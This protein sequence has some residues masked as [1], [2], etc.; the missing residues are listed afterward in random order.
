MSGLAGVTAGLL[1]ERS[2]TLLAANTEGSLQLPLDRTGR[3]TAIYFSETG[4]NLTDSFLDHWLQYG[5]S[6]TFGLPISE[7]ITQNGVQKQYFQNAVL[8]A[9]STS[10]EPTGVVTEDVGVQ[11]FRTYGIRSLYGVFVPNEADWYP[12]SIEGVHPLL[13]DYYRDSGSIAK[14]GLPIS[15]P[16]RRG[17]VVG[18]VFEKAHLVSGVDGIQVDPIGRLIANRTLDASDLQRTHPHHEAVEYESVNIDID[19]GPARE[20]LVDVNLTHKIATFLVGE[21]AVYRALI[22]SGAKHTPTPPGVFKIFLRRKV[23]R[24]IGGEFGTSD[25]YDFSNVFYTQYFTNDWIGFHYAYWH[26]GFGDAISHGCVNMRIEDSRWAWEFCSQG[27]IVNV[28]Y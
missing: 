3:P 9:D 5:K 14:W 4:H 24:M 6:G 13:W 7:G 19:Y 2:N 25:Y 12:Y 1:T 17:G 8:V 21:R 27:T 26:N 16:Y 28:H 20:R 10:N 18:Q 23:E 22:A 11:W 15:W